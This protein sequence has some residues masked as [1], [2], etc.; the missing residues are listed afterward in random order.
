MIGFVGG[1]LFDK[2][3][4]GYLAAW[5]SWGSNMVGATGSGY[6]ACIGGLGMTLGYCLLGIAVSA[7]I[8]YFGLPGS[9]VFLTQPCQNLDEI[10]QRE[11]RWER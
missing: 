7:N 3:G 2:L 8:S 1:V 10:S 4:P 11:E 9:S 5:T 6:P